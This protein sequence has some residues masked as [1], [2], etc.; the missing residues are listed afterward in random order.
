VPDTT[1]CSADERIGVQKLYLQCYVDQW[2]EEVALRLA[3]SGSG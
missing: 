2:R 3:E 1:L